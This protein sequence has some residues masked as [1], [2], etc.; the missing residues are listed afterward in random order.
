MQQKGERDEV[1]VCVRCVCDKGKVKRR[2]KKDIPKGCTSKWPDSC[3][4][5]V[6]T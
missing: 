5:V 4:W 6:E 2:W 3:C 1:C